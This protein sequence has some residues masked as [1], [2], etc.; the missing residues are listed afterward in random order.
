MK[1]MQKRI[2]IK[3]FVAKS[4]SFEL[5][6]EKFTLKGDSPHVER[7]EKVNEKR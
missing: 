1:E 7:F 2:T 6:T 5:K 4:A 3:K